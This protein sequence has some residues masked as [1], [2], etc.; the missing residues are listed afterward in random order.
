MGTK[1]TLTLDG[2]DLSTIGLILDDMDGWSDSAPR[3]HSFVGMPKRREWARVTGKPI[4]RPRELR[5]TGHVEGATMAAMRTRLHE[6]K[7][8]FSDNELGL[9]FSDASTEIMY[10]WLGDDGIDVSSLGPALASRRRRVS[11]HVVCPD[12]RIY[13]TITTNSSFGSTASAAVALGTAPVEPIIT[14]QTATTFDIIY[15]SSTGGERARFG[16]SGATGP[17][18]TIN[19][20]RQTILNSSN[21]SQIVS[22]SSGTDFFALDPFDGDWTT[23]AWP[24]LQIS[25]GTMTV[26][27]QRAYL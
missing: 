23:S 6:L 27:Y 24:T 18:F 22:K 13:E 14:V 7:Y 26:S 9:I 12:G 5:L 11:I 15:K 17:P 3:A 19:M 1:T 20:S 21:D 10:G 16:V 2:V 4:Y 8:R 25:A